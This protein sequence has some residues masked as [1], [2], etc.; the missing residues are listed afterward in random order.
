MPKR[1]RVYCSTE[2]TNVFVVQDS[3]PTTCPNNA[4]HTIVANSVCIDDEYFAGGHLFGDGSDGNV[5]VSS[6]VILAR[7]MYYRN[8]TITGANTITANG[9]RIFVQDTLSIVSGSIIANGGNGGLPTAGAIPHTAKTLGGGSIGGAGGATSGGS[10]SNGGTLTSNTRMGGLGG[11][12]GAG[13]TGSGVGPAGNAGTGTVPTDTNGGTNVFKIVQNALRGRDLA[14]VQLLGGSGGGGGGGG[15]TG[16]GGGGG[17]GGGVMLIAARN[18][19][20]TSGSITANGGGGSATPS[21]GGGG[22]G[23][24]GGG[25][26]VIIISTTDTSAMTITANGGNA[27][28]AAGT[29]STGTAGSAGQVFRIMV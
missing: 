16:T 2:A 28:A 29:G 27:G 10:G 18:I 7:D 9:Y 21:T 3:M 12:G 20:I 17:G 4:G 5:T 19:S 11:A 6:T 25:G 15:S 13:N 8:L 23:G 24:G 1:W 22:T 26:V 14:S